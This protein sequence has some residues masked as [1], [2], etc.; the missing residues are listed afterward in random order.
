MSSVTSPTSS[1]SFNSPPASPDIAKYEDSS[2]PP[3]P[4]TPLISYSPSETPENYVHPFLRNTKRACLT[5]VSLDQ[6]PMFQVNFSAEDIASMVKNTGKALKEHKEA[7]IKKNEL[8]SQKNNPEKD[9]YYD[10]SDIPTKEL[11]VNPPLLLSPMKIQCVE[12]TDIGVGRK[13]NEDASLHIETEDYILG[14]IFDGFGGSAAS[15]YVQQYFKSYFK[16][17]LD[18]AQG[19]PKKAIQNLF[20]EIQ[21]ELKESRLGACYMAGTTACVSLIDKKTGLHIVGTLADSES[22]TYRDGKCIPDSNVRNWTSNKDYNRAINNHYV[23]Q[24]GV[25]ADRESEPKRYRIELTNV[26]RA[27]GMVRS[28]KRLQK[29]KFLLNLVKPGDVVLVA[30]D[31]LWDYLSQEKILETLAMFK[32]DLEGAVD[33]LIVKAKL[34]MASAGGDN[35]TIIAYKIS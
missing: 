30:C 26:P 35:I 25:W 27:L 21:T 32:D 14:C 6:R 22:Y 11:L 16:T 12:K 24:S 9:C 1:A 23:E 31:G 19:D 29:A 33:S 8:G 18:E 10:V 17:A 2:T 13:E 3:T 5:K 20:Y 7:L 34:S 15:F 4:P 28:D